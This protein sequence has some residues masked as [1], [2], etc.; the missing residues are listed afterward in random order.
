MAERLIYREPAK[1]INVEVKPDRSRYVPGMPVKLTVRTTDEKGRP[2]AANVGI[3]VAD[4]SVLEMIDRREQAPH[5]PAMALLEPQVRELMDSEVYLSQDKQVDGVKPAEAL[6]L[7]LG[8]QGWRR[9][10]FVKPDEFVKRYGDQAKRMLA[11]KQPQP[12]ILNEMLRRRGAGAVLLEVGQEAQVGAD[13]KHDNL[14]AA[15]HM[16]PRFANASK[17]QMAEEKVEAQDADLR[18]RANKPI[19]QEDRSMQGEFIAAH[20]DLI[21]VREYAHDVPKDRVSD[22]RTDFTETIY[23]NANIATD[24]KTG[25]ATVTFDLSDSVTGFRARLMLSISTAPSVP[26]AR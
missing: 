7:L 13:V 3:T 16:P 6:D 5:L 12:M 26:A 17:Q 19:M 18:E 9:F 2:I 14:P 20:N 23:W 15:P 22:R 24:A 1:R 21:A 11:L 4:D 10:A 25:E 8:T